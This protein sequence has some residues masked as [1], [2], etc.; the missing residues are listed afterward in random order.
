MAVSRRGDTPPFPSL[1]RL[2]IARQGPGSTER[3][4]SR[5]LPAEAEQQG[6]RAG[7]REVV[8]MSG[9]WRRRRSSRRMTGVL[10]RGGQALKP[11]ERQ[12]PSRDALSAAVS[13]LGHAL[14]RAGLHA[15]L[16]RLSGSLL[17]AL[18]AQTLSAARAA[19]RCRERYLRSV[20]EPE[21]MLTS[22]APLACAAKPRGNCCC[23]EN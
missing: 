22:N 1:G 14:I 18:T 10:R 8:V 2:S 20:S 6:V 3:G 15:S 4:R 12:P 7:G 19:S 11:S 16:A 23:P 5:W 21:S 17:C 9:R 13:L